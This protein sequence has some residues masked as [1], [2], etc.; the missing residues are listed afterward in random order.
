MGENVF[1]FLGSR[2]TLGGGFIQFKIIYDNQT[3]SSDGTILSNLTQIVAQRH[4]HP[5]WK[6]EHTRTAGGT[7]IAHHKIYTLFL[8]S[9]AGATFARSAT[10]LKQKPKANRMLTVYFYRCVQCV[11]PS[12]QQELFAF[13][14]RHD[15]TGDK[16]TL[17]INTT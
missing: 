8:T 13:L 1:R 11:H 4:N 2:P 9:L 5:L 3:S 6:T 12:V 15:S 17:P 14:L 10:F 7:S 16:Y